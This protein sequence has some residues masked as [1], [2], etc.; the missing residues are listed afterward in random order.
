MDV[1]AA[2]G[3]LSDPFTASLPC[4]LQMGRPAQQDAYL[5]LKAKMRTPW[6]EP[7]TGR[8]GWRRGEEGEGR[9]KVERLQADIS[10]AQPSTTLT[11]PGS[12][13]RE[14]VVYS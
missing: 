6:G 8:P 7:S 10:D 4:L 3:P 9:K 1:W 11:S 13:H 2:R 12:Q 14:K 5:I